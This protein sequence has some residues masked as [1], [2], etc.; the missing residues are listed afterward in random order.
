M[1]DISATS[2]HN[3]TNSRKQHH[4]SQTDLQKTAREYSQHMRIVSLAQAKRS[5]AVDTT[6]GKTPLRMFMGQGQRGHRSTEIPVQT[7]KRL[8]FESFELG[9]NY[10]NNCALVIDTRTWREKNE[11]Q[12]H[13]II[14]HDLFAS[15]IDEQDKL[16][17]RTLKEIQEHVMEKA[18][19]KTV[20]ADA[21]QQPVASRASSTSQDNMH[22]PLDIGDMRSRKE[23]SQTEFPEILFRI[24]GSKFQL[25]EPFS[26]YPIDSSK[27]HVYK[28][29]I[30]RNTRSLFLANQ[31]CAKMIAL[32]MILGKPHNIGADPIIS[33]G[34][35]EQRWYVAPLLHGLSLSHT[36]VE[37][38]F[39]GST[40]HHD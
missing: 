16:D 1:G 25:K 34:I 13:V 15:K 39:I 11:V 4:I 10:P 31:V 35:R 5:S 40:Q 38:S 27:E 14:V 12:F 18:N 33:V 7:T 8:T 6:A 17:L 2:T 21:P 28:V 32:P 26:K 9:N 19:K 36:K 3:S 23:N 37:S 30:P 20:P 29:G 22:S 24:H